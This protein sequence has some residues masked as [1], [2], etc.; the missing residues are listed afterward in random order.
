MKNFCREK[1]EWLG[2][3]LLD[4]EIRSCPSSNYGGLTVKDPSSNDFFNFADIVDDRL[5]FLDDTR[6]DRCDFCWVNE[7]RNL[8]SRRLRNGRDIFDNKF[9]NATNV[10]PKKLDLILNPDCLNQCVYCCPNFSTSWT[11]DVIANGNYGHEHY[12]VNERVKLHYL[13]NQK[14]KSTSSKAQKLIEMLDDDFFDQVEEVWLGG[15]EPFL[16]SNFQLLVDTFIKK[17]KLKKVFIPTGLNFNVALLEKFRS[18]LTDTGK[19]H[20]QVSCEAVGSAHEFIRWG[21]QWNRWVTNFNYIDEHWRDQLTIK[22]T[23]TCLAMPGIVR[24]MKLYKNRNWGHCIVSE[25][26]FLS[27]HVIPRVIKEQ[28]LKDIVDVNS[29]NHEF[30]IFKKLI[31]DICSNTEDPAESLKQDLLAFLNKF[32]SNKKIELSTYLD[33]IFLSWLSSNSL[34]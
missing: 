13:A 4:W 32:A 5:T 33:P 23:L 34:A 22:P 17:E 2:I 11:K 18:N 14:Q 27:P 6:S 30:N 12:N 16:D 7:D 1:W 3:R 19:I 26:N 29:N 9:V 8:V 25:P 21:S 31:I 28:I 24:F 15:G 20:F 10:K